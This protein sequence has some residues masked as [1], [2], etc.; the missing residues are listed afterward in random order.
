MKQG[1]LKGDVKHQNYQN[2]RRSNKNTKNQKVEEFDFKD[3]CFIER[4]QNKCP[5]VMVQTD[6]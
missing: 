3:N 4:E 1:N 5:E 6:K 2:T